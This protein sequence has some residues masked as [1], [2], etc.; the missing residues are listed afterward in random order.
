M[1]KPKPGFVMLP[2]V[3]LPHT[4]EVAI[5]DYHAWGDDYFRKIERRSRIVAPLYHYTDMRGLEGILKNQEIW[6]TDYRHLNDKTELMHGIDLAKTLLAPRMA[7]GGYHSMLFG[8]I[9]DLLTKRNFGR[10]F[11]FFIASFSRNGDD[12]GQWR[13][14]ADDGRGVAIAFSHDVFA[15]TEEQSKD[16][17]KNTFTGPV[18][19]KDA[20]TRARHLKGIDKATSILDAALIYARHHLRNKTIGMEFL[21]RLARSVIA[22]P[23]IWNAITCKHPAYKHESEVRLVIV[24]EKKRL[25][26]KVSTRT[27]NGMVVRYIPHH[28]QL[29]DH[30]KVVSIVIGPA[31]PNNAEVNVRRIIKAAGLNYNVRI[32]RSRVPYR[33]FRNAA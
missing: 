24:A 20:H 23:L 11:D 3:D 12:L 2:H 32:R 28:L 27:R 17:R 15:P 8:W 19:Y 30:G 10:V 31:A 16:P 6:F 7:T 26:G 25:R 13:A 4:L 1:K 22:V 9:D 33:S 5:N 18:V 21:N 14:Y 29:R